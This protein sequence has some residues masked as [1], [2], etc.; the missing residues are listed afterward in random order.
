MNLRHRLQVVS[1]GPQANGTKV[2]I[3]GEEISGIRRVTLSCEAGDVWRATLEFIP[4]AVDFDALAVALSVEQQGE[5]VDV[6]DVTRFED[7]SRV[8]KVGK[9]PEGGA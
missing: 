7:E 5:P 1:K 9:P 2:H 4:G 3:N 6:I 8:F